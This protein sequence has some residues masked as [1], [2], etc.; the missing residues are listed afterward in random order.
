MKQK[1]EYLTHEIKPFIQ[2]D[3]KILILGTF[4]S[5]KSREFGFFY[6]HPRNRFW[7]VLSK[8]FNEKCPESIEEKKAFLEKHKIALWD[9]IGSCVITGAS[10]SSIKDP[11]P[12]NIEKAIKGTDIKQIF[13]TGQKANS[14]Y[15]R[16]CQK[17][18]GIEAIALPSTSPANAAA[19]LESLLEKYKVIL[20]Y[21]N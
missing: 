8:L 5:P 14:L 10:D 11:V 20:S 6:G 2:K 12:N 19:N 3:S 7:M 17:E 21:L 15:K 4:P 1:P 9:V 18:T 13:T 16:F